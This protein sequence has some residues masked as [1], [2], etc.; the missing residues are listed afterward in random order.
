MYKEDDPRLQ[1]L[2]E[3][4]IEAKQ[5]IQLIQQ[6]ELTLDEEEYERLLYNANVVGMY[7]ENVYNRELN[8]HTD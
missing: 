1:L 4:W 5:R 2:M 8:S 7:I 6:Q 3:L